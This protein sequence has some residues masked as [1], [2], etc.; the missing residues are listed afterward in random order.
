MYTNFQRFWRPRADTVGLV[1][2]ENH[3]WGEGN[4]ATLAYI[5]DMIQTYVVLTPSDVIVDWG[6]GAGKFLL[7]YFFLCKNRPIG[8]KLLGIE[9]SLEAFNVCVR[10]VRR[11]HSVVEGAP[12]QINLHY[13]DSTSVKRW[14]PVTV[15]VNYDGGVQSHVE[16]YHYILMRNCFQSESV[17]AIFSTKMNR[18]LFNIYFKDEPTYSTWVCHTSAQPLKFGKSSFTGYLWVRRTRSVVQYPTD[19]LL[20]SLLGPSYGTEPREIVTLSRRKR[21]TVSPKEDYMT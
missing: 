2:S 5:W 10:N 19:P 12:Y 6:V 20:Q 9:K 4:P 16:E 8:V 21:R 1:S 11:F 14:E 3:A 7:S 17:R 13:G 18:T 15:V